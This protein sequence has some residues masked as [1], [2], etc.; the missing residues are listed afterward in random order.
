[1]A[2]RYCSTFFVLVVAL[3]CL[4]ATNGYPQTIYDDDYSVGFRS[5]DVKPIGGLR[6]DLVRELGILRR[7]VYGL[8][9]ANARSN[10]LPAAENRLDTG[11]DP[12]QQ[13]QHHQQQQD[14]TDARP[15]RTCL[16]NG[17]M[18]HS[19]DYKD[20]VGA[21]KEA[22]YW[23]SDMS[24]GRKKRDALRNVMFRKANSGDR[25]FRGDD[26]GNNKRV[27]LRS[28]SDAAPHAAA[29]NK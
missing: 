4:S 25:K 24:P 15:K 1:M 8:L 11:S 26:D 2:L 17:G 21:V 6:P 27:P 19:C 3:I 29:A 18:S 28:E 23:N 13:Q 9:V 16:F 10:P 22:S 12:L 7:M 20:V 14:G 5:N